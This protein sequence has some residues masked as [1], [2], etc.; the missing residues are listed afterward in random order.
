MMRIDGIDIID[1]AQNNDVV[2]MK[3]LLEAGE[4]PNFLE[5]SFGITPLHFAILHR[6]VAVIP[7]LIA[8]GADIH[9]MTTAGE[10]PIDLAVELEYSEIVELLIKVHT[11]CP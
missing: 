8:A 6:S 1:A 3:Q 5:D 2:R 7:L 10:K 9:A 11:S 4:N